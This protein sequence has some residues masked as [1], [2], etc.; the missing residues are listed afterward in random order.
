MAEGMGVSA[1]YLSALEH[2]HRGAP[3]FDMLQR[4]TGYL[5]VIWDGAEELQRVA[6]LSSPRITIDTPSVLDF[7][8]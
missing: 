1:A 3:S 5:N 2:G 6:A 8:T 7:R 4:I